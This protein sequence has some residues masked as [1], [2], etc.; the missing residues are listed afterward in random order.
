MR[1]T[2]LILATVLMLGLVAGC[3]PAAE[4]EGTGASTEA[5]TAM[6]DEDMLNAQSDAFEAAWAEADAAGLAALF[7]EEGDSVAP[8]GQRFHGQEAI[9]GRYEGLMSGMY[10][11][12]TVSLENTSMSFPSDGVAIV[13]GTFAI[14]GMTNADGESMD[15]GGLFLNVAV[16]ENGEWKIH[17]SRPMMPMSAPDSGA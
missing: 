2:F 13:H 1:F 8:D 10:Q 16:K 17:C 4:E 7:T 12:T 14:S 5:E 6:S 15:V 9:Q 3:Q 11:G